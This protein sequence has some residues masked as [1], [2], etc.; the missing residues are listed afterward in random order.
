VAPAPAPPQAAAPVGQ[1]VTIALPPPRKVEAFEA[2]RAQAVAPVGPSVTIALPAPR[3]A[4]AARPATPPRIAVAVTAGE[5]R[6]ER[7]SLTEVA[8]VTSAG[9][10][11]KRQAG[12]PIKAAIQTASGTGPRL[13]V[14][15]AARVDR[16][17]AR[18][19]SYLGRFGWPQIEVGD[20]AAVRPRSL[21]V[22]PSGMQA[23]ARR[24]SAR[25]GFAMAPRKDVRQ[26]TILLGRDAAT[27][28]ALRAKA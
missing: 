18:T 4:P 8:L 3:P 5:P 2:P 24:L 15:N 12:Q 9:P 26:L 25:L 1:S 19:R 14:L 16:L 28:P 6:L 27:H 23:A 20:A 13:R 11:W 17:A 22:Y 7:L 10:R 21:I